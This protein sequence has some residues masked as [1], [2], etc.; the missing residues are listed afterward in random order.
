MHTDA[1]TQ[2]GE[3]SERK[4][5]WN[6]ASIGNCYRAFLAASRPDE[7]QEPVQKGWAELQHPI[8]YNAR[9]VW[10]DRLKRASC[11]LSS[12]QSGSVFCIYIVYVSGGLLLDG[13]HLTRIER[14]PID[15][16]PLLFWPVFYMPFMGGPLLLRL[17]QLWKKTQLCVCVCV[18]V[19]TQ[20]SGSRSAPE[21]MKGR[22]EERRSLERRA[23]QLPRPP[24]R[25][26]WRRALQDPG[27]VPSNL[28]ILFIRSIQEKNTSCSLLA[29][30]LDRRWR[31]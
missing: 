4:I 25:R 16:G 22:K 31:N 29:F 12:G 30:S 11:R 14:R 13:I 19:C 8:N 26:R 1:S 17:R 18:C 20:A 5:E 21:E 9:P 23:I 3:T 27:E 2:R 15:L 7:F 6:E 24:V 10:R 28:V